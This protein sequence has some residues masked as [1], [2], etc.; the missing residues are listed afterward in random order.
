MPL[1]RRQSLGAFGGG[2]GFR[3]VRGDIR[4]YL[5]NIVDWNYVGIME[6]KMET[7]GV[8]QGLYRGYMGVIL[9]L[10]WAYIG[11]N[12]KENGNY[13]FRGWRLGAILGLGFEP[14]AAR[15]RQGYSVKALAHLGLIVV[16]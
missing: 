4:S 7:T 3:G 14:R 2:G 11:D 10:Y 15:P 6:K 16:L 9:G 8:I 13:Y 5:G 1:W 12:G